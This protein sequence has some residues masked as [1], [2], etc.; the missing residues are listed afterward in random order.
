M[1]SSIVS[2]VFFQ[3]FSFQILFQ[4]VSNFIYY[5]RQGL[6]IFF[7]PFSLSPSIPSSHPFPLLFF[8]CL[9]CC[10]RPFIET[11]IFPTFNFLRTFVDDQLTISVQM[12]F[13]ILYSV[14]LICF[15][16]FPYYLNYYNF[17]IVSTIPHFEMGQCQ[18][19]IFVGFFFRVALNILGPSNFHIHFRIS[20]TKKSVGILTEIVLALQ[21]N[22]GRSNILYINISLFL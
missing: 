13:W 6:S 3:N 17:A 19:S 8:I 14:L 12:Y 10:F 4:F 20:F 15:S 21:I 11:I 9:S 18:F 5:V 2:Y 7:L 22:L 1:I 16:V